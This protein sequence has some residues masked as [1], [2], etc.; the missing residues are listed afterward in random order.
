MMS[1]MNINNLDEIHWDYIRLAE[2]SVARIAIIPMQDILGLDN[3]A[4][5]NTPSTIGINWKWRLQSD[6]LKAE[7]AKKLKKICK[8]YGRK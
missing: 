2:S 1:Y 8:T 6:E 3:S 4:R 7:D 5:M